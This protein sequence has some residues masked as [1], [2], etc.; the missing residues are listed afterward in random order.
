MSGKRYPL[1]NVGETFTHR[2]R[3]GETYTLRV[4]SSDDG[5]AFQIDQFPEM[6]FASPL[7]AAMFLVPDGQSVNARSFWNMN[8]KK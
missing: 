8:K 1:P 7:K 6:V 4:I 3:G 2:C 5:V